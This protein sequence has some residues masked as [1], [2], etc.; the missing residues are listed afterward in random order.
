[1]GYTLSGEGGSQNTGTIT[2]VDP[3]IN[4]TIE[5][6][7]AS[8]RCPTEYQAADPTAAVGD[9]GWEPNQTDIYTKFITF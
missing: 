5:I 3:N 6:T 8:G 4:I 7:D 1:Q 9:D 2:G